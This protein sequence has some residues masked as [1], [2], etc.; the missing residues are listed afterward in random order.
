M[1]I[2]AAAI[3]IEDQALA[4]IERHRAGRH[5]FA[6]PGGGVDKGETPEDA[7][8]REA[9]EELGLQ[10]RLL[11]LVAEVWFRGDHQYFYLVERV[12]GEFGSGTGPEYSR[13]APDDPRYGTYKPIWM[14]IADIPHSPVLPAEVADL[15]VRAESQG[16]PDAPLVV[17]EAE[18]L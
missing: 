13:N 3:L 8:V 14:K 15:I 16:W 18:I 12:G 6:I 5:Y 2:R 9:E 4:L 7:A 10:V 1:R 17:H 11:R